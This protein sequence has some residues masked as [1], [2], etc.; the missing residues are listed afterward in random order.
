MRTASCLIVRPGS[1]LPRGFFAAFCA[2]LRFYFLRFCFPL[3]CFLLF[4]FLLFYV[5]AFAP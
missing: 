4:C 1:T 3:F 5:S 2:F